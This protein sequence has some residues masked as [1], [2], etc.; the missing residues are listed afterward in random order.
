MNKVRSLSKWGVLCI[1]ENS[2]NAIL[3]EFNLSFDGVICI[4]KVPNSLTH[5]YI[6]YINVKENQGAEPV[7]YVQINIKFI[8]NRPYMDGE[9]LWYIYDIGIFRYLKQSELIIDNRKQFPWIE[10]PGGG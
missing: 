4:R 3:K 6:A 5:Y 1:W 10:S 2:I 7:K 8:K 9:F